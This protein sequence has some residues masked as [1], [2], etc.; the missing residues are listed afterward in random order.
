MFIPL[1][2]LKFSKFALLIIV[3]FM[4]TYS[5]QQ[6]VGLHHPLKLEYESEG[7]LP[8]RPHLSTNPKLV[9]T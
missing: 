7:G 1:G 8:L 5:G 2:C 9:D 3:F 4:C 6:G